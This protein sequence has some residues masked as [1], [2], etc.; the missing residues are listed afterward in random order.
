MGEGKVNE[1]EELN[2]I[3]YAE[4]ASDLGFQNIF[5][6]IESEDLNYILNSAEVTASSSDQNYNQVIF[7]EG[8]L[9]IPLDN[10]NIFLDFSNLFS[11]FPKTQS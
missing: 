10:N 9:V 1:I 8:E 6:K 3:F 7:K 2:G 11:C 4:G 5:A